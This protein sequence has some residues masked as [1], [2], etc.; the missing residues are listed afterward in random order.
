MAKFTF[1]ESAE[2]KQEVSAHQAEEIKD[3]YKKQSKEIQLKAS[4]L[5]NDKSGLRAIQIAQLQD[6]VD[7]SLSTITKQISAAVKNNSEIVVGAVTNDAKKF[8]QQIG[9]KAGEA[10]AKV[11]EKIVKQITTGQVYQ[12]GWTLSKALWKDEN[13]NRQAIQNLIASGV[14]A[15]KSTYDI[16]KSVEQYVDPT[17][18]KPWN[19]NKVYPN[20]TKVIDYN[21]QRLARTMVN[22]A[23]QQGVKESIKDNPFIDLVRWLSA[24]SHRS[25][26][27]CKTRNNKLFEKDKVPL[28]HP[29][30]M[31]TL[32]PYVEY[33]LESYAVV[34]KEWKNS[35]DGS[36]S[37]LD[38]YAES[39]GYNIKTKTPKVS[40]TPKTPKTP[41]VPAV[42]KVPKTPKVKN[43]MPTVKTANVVSQSSTDFD[44]QLWND[45]Y[46]AMK[47]RATNSKL[48]G[49][50]DEL[51]DSYSSWAYYLTPSERRA[52]ETY[53]SGSYR[54]INT[55]LR[56]QEIPD[57]G[58]EDIIK[59]AKSAMS[60]ASLPEET[61]T[62]RGIDIGG[63]LGATG[64]DDKDRFWFYDNYRSL[65]N[66]IGNDKGFVSTSIV[67]PWREDINMILK[68]PKGYKGAYIDKISIHKGEHELLLDADVT[69][70][71][72]DIIEERS[73]I[74]KVYA[75][76]LPK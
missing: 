19:W 12:K 42:P 29:N 67:S 3:I 59:K 70:V 31:C 49:A 65:V 75:E 20:S 60:K 40:A 61:Y 76:V 53:T 45:N 13:Q 56:G 71:I 10:Y 8:A 57:R 37:Y 28:D 18:K 41:K 36:Y 58:T 39:L 38:K 7:K 15:N 21:A 4:S 9:L 52:I 51:A 35:T 30:G 74:F 43:S 47:D 72:K 62:G 34:I 22:H 63:I 32:A 66:S 50:T 64:N 16:A 24:M 69:F 46:Q 73:G 27:M 5:K 55:A 44:M 33:D 68:V 54:V 48:S 26:E 11:P 6:S 2:I 17:A 1:L 14:V 23:Y 25:C